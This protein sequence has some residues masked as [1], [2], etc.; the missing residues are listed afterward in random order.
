VASFVSTL[1]EVEVGSYR[2]LF[3]FLLITFSDYASRV[4]EEMKRQ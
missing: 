1:Q 2:W 3:L 4:R